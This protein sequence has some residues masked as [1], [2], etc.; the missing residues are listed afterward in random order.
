M[1]YLGTD[2]TGGCCMSY[3]DSPSTTSATTYQLYLRAYS[4]IGTA[5]INNGT[6]KGSITCME[7]KG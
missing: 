5:E 7:I 1:F 2:I 4:A 6:T 3:L